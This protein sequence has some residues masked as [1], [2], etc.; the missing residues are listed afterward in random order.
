MTQAASSNTRP[1]KAAIA[2]GCLGLAGLAVFTAMASLS[3]KAPEVARP[4]AV[5]GPLHA[6]VVKRPAGAP[7]IATGLAN[8]HGEAVTIA[9]STC[10]A[11]TQ[12]NVETR[13]AAELDE[14]H[15]G[16]TYAHGNLTCLSCHNA[17]NYDTLRMA[18]SRQVAFEE[19]MTL[20]SQCHGSQRRD[21]DMGLH[22]GMTG[23]WDLS[24]GGRTRNT[25]VNCHDPHAP[26][27]PMVLPVLPPRDRISVPLKSR[28]NSP[29]H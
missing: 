4:A 6:V 24:K 15:Q 18:D 2:F 13:S 21:Y 9:C 22:G 1:R 26:A 5:R 11:T 17:A 12:P 23:Y 28:T 19:V 3:G 20:C 16:L 14:F 7:R 8:H 10:H 29:N 27:F 25:C